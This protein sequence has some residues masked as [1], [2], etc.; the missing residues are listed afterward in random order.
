[1]T[2]VNMHRGARATLQDVARE[3]GVSIKTVSRVVNHERSVS[4]AMVERVVEVI[5]RL[6]YQPNE[7]AR[8]LRGNRTRTVGLMIADVSNPFFAECCKA[9]DEVA[10]SHGYSVIL[11]ASAEDAESERE[12]IG[13][14]TRRRVDGLLLAPAAG[15]QSHREL[16]LVAGPAVVAFDRPFEGAET[17][18]VLVTN[19]D[20]ARE[21]AE[22]LVG[23]R[24]RRIAF[25]GDDGRIYTARERLEGYREAMESSGL[26][27]IH[28]LGTGSIAAAEKAT[29][30]LLEMQDPPTA[31]LAGNGLIT[32]GV[33][34][35]LDRAGLR[36][37]GDVAVVGFDDFDL[38][39][40]LSPRLTAVR[41]PTRELGRRAAELLF[42]RLEGRDSSP[43]RHLVLPTE[44]V[45]RGSCGCD[46]R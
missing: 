10:R 34:R 32:A 16:D 3:A 27:A 25:L 11:C 29:D 43:P 41:Q 36:V 7:L 46:V 4:P 15:G 21:A 12:Y 5:S 30:E 31:F 17:D 19:R 35:T 33:L 42:D 28:R 39:S 13:L 22:H 24:H 23:H 44:L 45:V 6:G 26:E 9:I 38:M 18:A 1:M 37:P 8:S 14:L 2:D 20:G 40:A